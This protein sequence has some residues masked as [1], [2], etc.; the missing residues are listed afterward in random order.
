MCS[1]APLQGSPT[2]AVCAFYFLYTYRPFW[3]AY[4]V[5]KA[6]LDMMTHV[7]RVEM[8]PFGVNVVLIKP[9][10]IK[11]LIIGCVR[12]QPKSCLLDLSCYLNCI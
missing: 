9:G 2:R 1:S 8:A 5:S 11:S 4:N 3:G 10:F 7:M 6:A 12:S